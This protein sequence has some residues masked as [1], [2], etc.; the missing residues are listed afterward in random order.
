MGLLKPACRVP[1]S[2][3]QRGKEKELM[4]SRHSSIV[5]IALVAFTTLACSLAAA[6]LSAEKVAA[7]NRIL[8]QAKAT[9]SK[10][11]PSRQ[12]ML[13]AN[14][15]ISHLADRWPT[16][17]MRLLDR[18]FPSRAPNSENMP[19]FSDRRDDDDIIPVSDP[20]T[21]IAYS[22]FAGFTQSTTSTAR[23]GDS[24][25]VGYDDSGSVFE[26][27]Y[28]FTGT[29]GES[30]SGS[31]Y[32]TD[33]GRSFTDIG[34]INPGPNLYNFLGGDPVVTCAD[35]HTFYVSQT[36]LF[37]DASLN[38]WA[39]IAVNASTDGGKTWNDPVAAI[40]KDGTAH[41]LD[42][43]WSAI[44]PSNHKRIFVSYTDFDY[45]MTSAACGNATRTAIEFVESD[46]GG[47]TWS[48][49]RV[50][51]EVCG[52][53]DVDGSQIAVSSKGTLYISWV[54]FGSN[55]PL[56]P[57]AIQISSYAKGK[58]SGPVTVESALQPGGDAYYL[59]GEFHDGVEMAMA[60][61]HS[62]TRTD[63]ALYVTW[64][65]GRDKTVSDPF[66][67]QGYYAYDDV[68]LRA[69]FDGGNSWGAAPIKV[70]SDFQSHLAGGRDHYQPGVAVDKWGRV[71][72]CW[73]DRRGDW[74]NFAIRRHCGVSAPRGA[75]FSD[76]DIGLPSFAPTHGNDLLVS[77]AYMGNYDQLTSDFLNLE[78]GFIG[79][80]QSQTVRGNPDVVAHRIE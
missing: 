40:A 70:N 59:Q 34:P 17:G 53:A 43:P 26:T 47:A 36:F 69:S 19:R 56:G 9:I 39:A 3:T 20:S 71:A 7:T 49:P 58:L 23:C 28:F 16:Y 51:M 29:G 66:A 38:P 4:Q 64:A 80:S 37:D 72:V 18:S 60:I 5:I 1:T 54:N 15:N 31:S 79:A 74:Q 62:G 46:D 8:Q 21:D 48:A 22:A 11:P 61:D 44:D 55:S 35:S 50:A 57:R 30:F 24:V 41:V 67:L 6:Q 76:Y 77:P 73:Y 75:R 32:S 13:G 27:P 42:K 52:S 65:D 63:G 14:A 45:T 12:M 68:L 78:P 25:V 33:G 2:Q 10:L